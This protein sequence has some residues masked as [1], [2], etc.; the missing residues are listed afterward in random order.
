MQKSLD[1]ACAAPHIF[2]KLKEKSQVFEVFSILMEIHKRTL[3]NGESAEANTYKLY[4]DK[5]KLHK[6]AHEP[7]RSTFSY[8][9]A[10]AHEHSQMLLEVETAEL[11]R[12]LSKHI[13]MHVKRHGEI[14]D[15]CSL[16]ETVRGVAANLEAALSPS[17]QKGAQRVDEA[18]R[19]C[20]DALSSPLL[21]ALLLCMLHLKNA[22]PCAVL[23]ILKRLCRVEC[24]V[25]TNGGEGCTSP[26]VHINA[27]MLR[28]VLVDLAKK[29]TPGLFD[30]LL[31]I[32]G[33]AQEISQYYGIVLYAVCREV[34]TVERLVDVFRRPAREYMHK[35]H[36]ADAH[37]TR[38]MQ[39]LCT[40]KYLGA[41]CGDS[42]VQSVRTLVAEVLQECKG[43]HI[44]VETVERALGQES[45]ICTAGTLLYMA[46]D[47]PVEPSLE[48][49]AEL[50]MSVYSVMALLHKKPSRAVLAD[51]VRENTEASLLYVHCVL[52]LAPEMV[53]E[54]GVSSV[55]AE[56]E[57]SSAIEYICLAYRHGKPWKGIVSRHKEHCVESKRR[58]AAE[59]PEHL[60]KAGQEKKRRSACKVCSVDRAV[61]RCARAIRRKSMMWM[62]AEGDADGIAQYFAENAPSPSAMAVLLERINPSI[63]IRVGGSKALRHLDP[64]EHFRYP[65]SVRMLPILAH[66]Q[67]AME[68]IKRVFG[69]GDAQK[70]TIWLLFL[71]S[72]MC[73]MYGMSCVLTEGLELQV[74]IRSP[75]IAHSVCERYSQ[76]REEAIIQTSLGVLEGSINSTEQEKKNVLCALK[77]LA[78][79]T[80]DLSVS[81]DICSYL[82][83]KAKGCTF[84][85]FLEGLALPVSGKQG[86]TTFA[87]CLSKAQ[88]LM[89]I[90]ETVDP[91]N[92]PKDAVDLSPARLVREK[93]ELFR[94]VS[95]LPLV[96]QKAIEE[97]FA[98]KNSFYTAHMHSM[99]LVLA[100]ESEVR[101]AVEVY[102]DSALEEKE[103]TSDGVC[104]LKHPCVHVAHAFLRAIYPEKYFLFF[105]LTKLLGEEKPLTALE[106]YAM[107]L[108]LEYLRVYDSSM[109]SEAKRLF[110]MRLENADSLEKSA[111]TLSGA[112]VSSMVPACAEDERIS[113]LLRRHG[114]MSRP[115]RGIVLAKCQN[116]FFTRHYNFSSISD[117]FGA[118]FKKLAP[119]ANLSL[120]VFMCD[121]PSAPEQILEKIPCASSRDFLQM[122]YYANCSAPVQK[123]HPYFRIIQ[124]MRADRGICAAE[125]ASEAVPEKSAYE[126]ISMYENRESDNGFITDPN[127]E[128]HSDA[129]LEVED[130]LEASRKLT[131]W[132]KAVGSVG[133]QDFILVNNQQAPA[134]Y[135]NFLLA[136]KAQERY[137]FINSV[138][139]GAPYTGNSEIEEML[140]ICTRRKAEVSAALE[141]KRVLTKGGMHCV[142]AALEKK[143]LGMPAETYYMRAHATKKSPEMALLLPRAGLE[144]ACDAKR[145]SLAASLFL[146]KISNNMNTFKDPLQVLSKIESDCLSRAG[147]GC[148]ERSKAAHF[149]KGLSGRRKRKTFLQKQSAEEAELLAKAVSAKIQYTLKEFKSKPI[150]ILNMHVKPASE[151]DFGPSRMLVLESLAKTCL[152]IFNRHAMNLQDRAAPQ[153]PSRPKTKSTILQKE[154]AAAKELHDRRFRQQTEVEE[155]ALRMGISFYI[156]LVE[157]SKSV[158]HVI[159]LVHLLFSE[160]V[161]ERTVREASMDGI[162]IKCFFPLKQQIIS[163]YFH[164]KA[165]RQTARALYAHLSLLI[166]RFLC[167]M[168]LSVVYDIILREDKDSS[169]SSIPASTRMHAEAVIRQYKSMYEQAQTDAPISAAFPQGTHLLTSPNTPNTAQVYIHRVMSSAEKLKGINKPVLISLQGTDGVVYKEI[170]K[171][172]DD[173]RQDILSIQVFMYMNTVLASSGHTQFIKERVRT[174]N[175]VALDKLFGVIQFI[176]TAE[177]IGNVIESLHKKHYP[178]EI[179]N[180]RCRAILVKKIDAPLEEKIKALQ[181]LNREYSPVLKKVFSGKG[182][183]EY[184]KQ[185]KAFTS[186]FAITSIATYILGLGDRHPQNI[187]LDR[188]TQELINI[189]LN[190]IF[191]Q[192]RA[193]SISEKVP[194]RMTANMQ[195]GLITGNA[196]SYERIMCAFLAS[197][198]ESKETL[199]VFV[200]ILKSEPL[201]RWK[202]IQKIAQLDTL[203]SDYKSIMGRLKDK[204]NGVED[205]FVLSNTAHVQCLVQRAVDISNQASI[206]PGWSPWM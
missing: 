44:S 170:L 1:N 68:R 140:Y 76:K 17:A 67:K 155:A 78:K 186:S 198:K 139:T 167:E 94:A 26:P 23:E 87:R 93:A 157:E 203:F 151:M 64:S 115:R 120:L 32:A 106:V 109:H 30:F 9:T 72:V 7:R 58:H 57:K 65:E 91:C 45:I 53:L 66:S 42:V 33:K 119:F 39:V 196:H 125:L 166:E 60:Q 159:S 54:P 81:K 84:S 182:P 24:A 63:C 147:A 110:F 5:V 204:L 89:D 75:K 86:E 77:A 122:F 74:L 97:Y 98:H 73:Q 175:I 138:K 20:A 47:I 113:T 199:L 112:S 92:T 114:P 173:L 12:L 15:Q 180:K 40:A 100:R 126:E 178:H 163:K 188:R 55:F 187:L 194:F 31:E 62:I 108:V 171:K 137:Q 8:S 13:A 195:Q 46:R 177:P 161:P 179:D 145:R 14:E 50:K 52:L 25:K 174:Y 3:Q 135:V 107:R 193:L 82:Q 102:Y 176:S 189:D 206:Y 181:L 70:Q 154:E 150:D 41:L 34:Q 205:G 130:I 59:S 38:F 127:P 143:W 48:M 69:P 105:L 142:L 10:A 172:N 96:E 168:P 131:T 18:R 118:Y 141:K 128:M 51:A 123:E 191:D 146:F 83:K 19:V 16:L 129:L 133:M 116:A 22:E 202:A 4:C 61:E 185:R 201:Q 153:A 49:D 104:S 149:L 11:G 29:S 111:D 90:F 101:K 134:H 190:L 37:Y 35:P 21:D 56:A 162:P 71:E 148:L 36:D 136:R 121:L 2:G 144:S 184:C 192:A 165:S 95:E 169:V 99:Q 200:G 79:H 85:E 80:P 160:H 27:R 197:L 124:V 88:A 132:N 156:K 117:L 164:L 158:Q 103:P 183:F 43:E 152:T 28:A 6:K